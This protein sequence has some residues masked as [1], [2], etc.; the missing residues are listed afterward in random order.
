MQAIEL[1]KELFKGTE[2]RIFGTLESPLFVA[3]DIAKILEIKHIATSINKFED[4]K[5]SGVR[6]TDPHGRMQDTVVL[7]EAGLYSLVLKSKKPIAKEFEKWV[8]T[9]V[10]PNIRKNG[11][12]DI[13]KDNNQRA[14]QLEIDLEES[15][16][17]IERL[18]LDYKPSIKYHTVDFNEFAD[19][20]CIYLIHIMTDYFKFGVSSGIDN[21]MS[22]HFNNFKKLNHRP[23]IVNIW[24]CNKAKIMK[25]TEKK[26]KNYAKQNNILVKAF[27]Q[28]EIMKTDNI[29]HIVEKITK[30][31]DNQNNVDVGTIEIK[32]MELTNEGKRLDIELKK[33]DIEF[34]KISSLSNVDKQK[35]EIKSTSIIET[36]T[37]S[38]SDEDNIEDPGDIIME[39]PEIEPVIP[40]IK[41]IFQKRPED[42]IAEFMKNNKY[43]TKEYQNTSIYADYTTF[44]IEIDVTPVGSTKL[45]KELKARGFVGTVIRHHEQI[46]GKTN[47]TQW[48]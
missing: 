7:T 33:L 15:R 22:D 39:L 37:I 30:Y 48:Y 9:E 21:R 20:S 6:T 24:K 45:Y 44:C 43:G 5:K 28:T 3:N 11:K 27:G 25:T 38:D 47:S 29:D 14:Q 41:Q 17:E 2:V 10:L 8:L 4:Y 35:I 13:M 46:G 23:T 18:K 34:F 16:T 36:I 32:K 31:I 1:T 26:I 40:Q 42:P 19:D 12:Y